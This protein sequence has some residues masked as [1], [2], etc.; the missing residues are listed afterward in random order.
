MDN[1]R[2]DLP[3]T[4]MQRR[5]SVL[6]LLLMSLVFPLIY[7]ASQMV[8]GSV[9]SIF[10]S[11]RTAMSTLI[12]SDAALEATIETA[13][14]DAVATTM[15]LL[16]LMSVIYCL[17]TIAAAVVT[18][19][20][21]AGWGRTLVREL[22]LG[23]SGPL[24]LLAALI[25]G[26]AFNVATTF[27]LELIPVPQVMLDQYNE[28]VGNMIYNV[29]PLMMVSIGLL[30]PI[31]EELAFRI[32]PMRTLRT[33]FT[34]GAA[35]LITG[36]VFALAHMVP[37]QMLYVLP[38]GV[39][40]GLIFAWCGGGASIAAHVGYNSFAVIVMLLSDSSASAESV[41]YTAA[42]LLIPCI[43]G[44]AVSALCLTVLYK[45]RKPES[46]DIDLISE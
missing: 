1:N 36:V 21:R 45:R 24:G 43:A 41:T 5:P 10:V 12:T 33:M 9:V 34:G 29:S 32:M 18:V 14:E 27:A 28:Q 3:Q 15:E 40:L 6:K 39:L 44:F 4:P 13:V 7:M 20:V 31:A 30:I 2:F 25:F 46:T 26:A 11:M 37:L 38:T 35:A 23:D 16:P 22:R 42:D 19:G 8:V 17:I